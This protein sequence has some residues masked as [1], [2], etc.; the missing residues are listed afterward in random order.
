[1]TQYHNIERFLAETVGLE[2]ESIGRKS[3]KDAV[4][5]L[6]KTSMVDDVNHYLKMLESDPEEIQKLIEKVIVPETWFFRDRDAFHF[7]KGYAEHAYFS[8]F[9]GKK[10]RV[11]SAPCSTGE[12]PYSIAMTLLE[13]GLPAEV[14]RIDA[15]DIS[16]KAIETARTGIYGKNSFRGENKAYQDQYFTSMEEG[17]KLDPSIA[18]LVHFSKDNFVQPH[19]MQDYEPYQIIFC[20]NLLIY[21]TDDARKSVFANLDRLLLSKGAI[22]TGHSEGMSFLQYGYSPVKHSRS[23]AFRKTGTSAT[24]VCRD[25]PTFNV[26]ARPGI[27]RPLTHKKNLSVDQ[28]GAPTL[29]CRTIMPGHPSETATCLRAVTHRQTAFPRSKPLSNSTE[30]K[31]VPGPG[32]HDSGCGAEMFATIRALADR[33][34][35]EEALTLCEQF[36]KEHRHNKEAY[37]LMGLINFALNAFGKAEA[38]FQKA[39]YL[40]PNYY[41]ALLHMSLLY[42]KKGDQ[43]KVSVIR[44]RIKRFKEKE[45]PSGS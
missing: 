26:Q 44:G 22:F 7:L 41:E 40:D 16:R 23:F 17:F 39:L 25:L 35:L 24:D 12:E 32:A 43:A 2:S 36:L 11:L 1:M 14:F 21:L 20:K 45:V 31:V 29:P 27:R 4:N 19:T 42:E 33:G 13:A 15:I 38:F 34:A 5:A 18:R 10:L 8:E 30:A 6:M 28:A 37:Y 3:I 9:E